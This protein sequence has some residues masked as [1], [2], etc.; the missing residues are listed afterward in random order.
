LKDR[1]QDLIS[2]LNLRRYIKGSTI[3]PGTVI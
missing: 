3:A 1:F 2:N